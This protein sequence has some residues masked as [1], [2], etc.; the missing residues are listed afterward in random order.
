MAK[1]GHDYGI[2]D[3]NK[4]TFFVYAVM[5]NTVQLAEHLESGNLVH[6]RSFPFFLLSL[7][8]FRFDNFDV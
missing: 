7:P 5:C 6:F 8:L 4:S 3:K 2:N 1:E